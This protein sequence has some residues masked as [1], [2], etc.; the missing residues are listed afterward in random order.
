[1]EQVRLQ[2]YLADCGVASRRKSEEIIKSGRVTVNG[3]VI[4]EM[5]YKVACGDEVRVDGKKVMPEESKV[6]IALNKPYGYVTTVKD[7]FGRPAVVDLVRD[8]KVRLFPVGRLDYDTSG[9]IILTNDGDFTYRLTHPKH[10]IKKVYIA[11]VLGTFTKQEITKFE[12][13]LEIDDYVTAPSK[14]R[15]LESDAKTSTVEITIHE[16]KNRQVRKMCEKVG[17]PVVMLKRIS[18]G[19][20]QLDGLPE[21]KWRELTKDELAKVWKDIT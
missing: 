19:N 14:I 10:E 7:Q 13:G 6:Y 21:G 17:H 4:T 9:L 8:I 18:I 11:K 20:I 16:G 12:S 5:G 3:A 1:M 15:V 2:K